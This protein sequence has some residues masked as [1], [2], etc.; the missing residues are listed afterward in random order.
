MN[1][2]KFGSVHLVRPSL[3]IMQAGRDRRARLLRSTFAPGVY[4][5]R[6]GAQILNMLYEHED[7]FLRKKVISELSSR[8]ALDMVLHLYDQTKS[9]PEDEIARSPRALSE[10]RSIVPVLRRAIKYIIELMCIERPIEP[11][12]I[13]ARVAG[14]VLETAI[15]VTEVLVSLYEMSN[16]CFHLFPDHSEVEV[17]PPDS[18]Q[19]LETRIKEPFMGYDT[20][21]LQRVDRDVQRRDE[22]IRGHLFEFQV[23]I[24][25]RI[26]D[27]VFENEF[28]YSYGTAI[29]ILRSIIQDV[30]PPP[31]GFP[32]LFISRERLNEFASRLEVSVDQLNQ[33]VNAFTVR[34][35]SLEEDDRV[36]WK[37]KQHSR[38]LRRGFF[39]FP[40]ESG[41]HLAFS[42]SMAVECMMLLVSGLCYQKIPREWRTQKV[43]KAVS[44][45]SNA[46]GRWFEQKVVEVLATLGLEGRGWTGTIGQGESK[47]EIP[48]N[49]GQ[50][51]YLGVLRSD[52]LLVLCE[53]KMV[54]GAVE[55]VYWRDDVG[56]FVSQSKNFCAQLR[57]KADWVRENRAAICS[58]FDMDPNC[59]IGIS[60]ITLYPSIAQMFTADIPCV[61]LTEFAFDF[62]ERR[63]VWPY[64]T[65]LV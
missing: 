4:A 65:G 14:D 5:G 8:D 28:G 57:R 1:I 35:D 30:T 11:L 24:H 27:T 63:N 51:D 62:R 60:L 39:E 20:A 32:T 46:G 54:E 64:P 56:Q 13:S 47:I 26:L 48:P 34:A 18:E 16:R 41:P 21:F 31:N 12:Q 55:G 29:G 3:R 22:V 40:H 44:Q 6:D 38:A 23:P 9:Q 58:C 61:S 19:D 42:R 2:V 17:F 50:I 59:S 7:A 25:Q 36:L 53:V 37:P 15:D 10:W 33:I 52:K 43:I 45:L 49:V